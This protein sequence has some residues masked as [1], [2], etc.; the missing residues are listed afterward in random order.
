MKQFDG[1][2]LRIE[3]NN[4]FINREPETPEEGRL[5]FVAIEKVMVD[6][7]DS[8]ARSAIMEGMKKK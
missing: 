1:F 4:V 5:L 7:L 2:T 6:M 3:G 8:M